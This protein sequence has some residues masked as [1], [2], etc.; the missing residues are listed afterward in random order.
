MPWPTA[1]RTWSPPASPSPATTPS[2][3]HAAP[4]GRLHRW[5]EGAFNGLQN[6]YRRTLH[7][8]LQHRVLVLAVALL[9]A[10]LTGVLLKV[11]PQ[12]FIPTDDTGSVLILT[13]AAQDIWA[14]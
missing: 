10:V 8:S 11:L 6:L 13:D 1:R 5:S 2:S 7:I 12:G 3:P 9:M 4:A 14:T